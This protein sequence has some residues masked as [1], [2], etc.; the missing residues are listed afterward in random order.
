MMDNCTSM[1]GLVTTQVDAIIAALQQRKEELI[2]Y[3]RREKDYKLRSLKAE[4]SSLTHRLQQTTALI[5][6]CIE[7]LKETDPSAY[8]QIGSLLLAR[9][10]H[11]EVAWACDD[12]SA[13]STDGSAI[14]I[15]PGRTRSS[16][17]SASSITG[18]YNSALFNPDFDLTLDDRSVLAAIRQ[19]NFIQMK[20]PGPVQMIP[21]ECTAENN[22]ITV[23]WQPPPTSFVEGYVLEI[24][25]GAGGTYREV[26]CGKETICTV[27][28]LHFNS[29]YLA[30][31]KA[32]NSTGEGDYSETINLRTA[33]VA[34]FSF[35]PSGAAHGARLSNENC[36]VTSDSYEPRVVLGSVGFARGVHYWEYTVDKYDASADPS[37]GVARLDV[38]KEEMLG[39]D[40]KGWGMYIDHQRS[41]FIHCG[42]H[43]CRTEGG[44]TAG[45]T[46]GV[47]LDLDK[48]QI[49]FYVNDEQQ[50]P[51]AFTN[52]FGV[53]YPAVSLNC[54]VTVS[55][56]T[57]LDLPSDSETS[58][59]GTRC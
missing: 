55:V 9:V 54:N 13:S 27:D 40:D 59:S 26:Y 1:E 56:H 49:T 8:L 52:L 3:I 19:L 34:W 38:N 12:D 39:K 43:S 46:I 11:L 15:S 37:F 44:I 53:F 21:E 51:I 17:S 20:P 7:A 28:G 23:A 42:V 29:I 33:E 31:V 14:Q 48:R 36:T 6:F 18:G 25:D 41:W 32:F 47:L 50:G 35:D 30:R 57:G 22:S 10:A 45:S 58:D 4:V 24:D 5:H 16:V 2:T